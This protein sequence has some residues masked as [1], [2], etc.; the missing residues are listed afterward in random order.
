MKKSLLAL[1]LI[2]IGLFSSVHVSAQ[3]AD[4]TWEDPTPFS[5]ESF[6]SQVVEETDDAYYVLKTSV[7]GISSNDILLEKYSKNDFSYLAGFPVY[8]ETMYSKDPTEKRPMDYDKI[9]MVQDGFLVF[10]TEFILEKK[11]FTSYCQKFSFEGQT[12]GELKQ[13]EVFTGDDK[14]VIGKYEFTPS[15]FGDG[16]I[17]TY[18]RPFI[19]YSNEFFRFKFFD[20]NLE[21]KWTKE[22][23][24]PFPGKEFEVK[25]IRTSVD[26]MVYVMVKV[27]DDSEKER[28]KKGNRNVTYSF[29]LLSFH[30]NPEDTSKQ[31]NNM[32]VRLNKKYIT[33]VAYVINEH[34]EIVCSGYF[35]DKKDMAISGAFYMLIESVGGQVRT[36]DMSDFSKD[37]LAKFVDT[38]NPDRGIGMRDFV[39]QDLEIMNDGTIYLIGEQYYEKIMC[40]GQPPKLNCITEYYYNDIVVT[41]ISNEGKIEWTSNI[42]KR[43]YDRESGFLL[44]YTY[45]MMDNGRI[46]FIYNDAPKNM[47]TENPLEFKYVNKN[48]MVAIVADVNKEGKV[49]REY[50][51]EGK[52]AKIMIRPKTH[53]FVKD[54]LV[55]YG[56]QGNKQYWGKLRV[57]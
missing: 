40:S 21:E 51:Q 4:I 54:D 32:P 18:S 27:L 56:L 15:P 22:F 31:F 52:N 36:S 37:F 50:L 3:V 43:S 19:L 53:L 28:E 16:F 39:L 20:F 29:N 24:F 57:Y 41:R 46:V 49:H 10:F 33:D 13:L 11:T 48:G 47:Q 8:S 26:S 55:I 38:K 2:S 42:P 5:K 17:L 9:I 7:T 44:S 45:K 14:T 23:L 25:Q 12:I 1:S 30:M 34:K 6:F 35:A